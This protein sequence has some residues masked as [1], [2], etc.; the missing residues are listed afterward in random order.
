MQLLPT[1]KQ[2]LVAAVKTWQSFSKEETA[3][4]D[5]MFMTFRL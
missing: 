1:N 3:V 2:Q 4:S 5:V